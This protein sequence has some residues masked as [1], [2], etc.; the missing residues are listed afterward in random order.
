[1]SWTI[2][3]RWRRARAVFVIP[4]QAG[5]HLDLSFSFL[6]SRASTRPL[7][8]RVTFFACAKKVTK[9]STPQV[10]RLPGI[11][12]SRSASGLRGSL[13]V[14]PCTCSE[15]A[16]I[17]RAPQR[18]FPPPARRAT[19]GPVGRHPAAEERATAFP[20]S[21]ST[22]RLLRAVQGWTNLELG[23]RGAVRGA[24]HR[25][26]SRKMPEGA[27]RWIAAPAQ[28]YTDVLS[29]QPGCGEKRRGACGA[30]CAANHRVRRLAFWLLLGNAKS[31]R[32]A[33]RRD[34][35]LFLNDDW[36]LACAGMTSGHAPT[37]KLAPRQE[38]TSEA[39]QVN[40]PRTT[41]DRCAGTGA[42]WRRREPVRQC[43]NVPRRP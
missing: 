38:K 23:V 33:A 27:R 34:E 6:R 9:E 4:A 14:R 12:P 5:I 7:A 21:T 39:R 43:G 40:A 13:N 20:Y 11:L 31:N 30:R 25:S 36:I 8:E 41:A 32:L 3:V 2:S 15:L 18:A 29:A 16:R 10:S 24:E 35:A 1:M 28:Q 22:T 42:A 26:R 37:A 19:W 17:L